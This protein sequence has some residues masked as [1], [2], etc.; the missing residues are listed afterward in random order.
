M[1]NRRLSSSLSFAVPILLLLGVGLGAQESPRGSQETASARPA[2]VPESFAITPFGYFHPSCVRSLAENELV[3]ADGRV[4]HANGTT[5][6]QAPACGFPHFTATGV[7]VTE[8]AK[9]PLEANLAAGNLPTIHGWLEYVSATTDT[10]YREISATWPVPAAPATIQGQTLFFFP[11]FEDYN[12]ILSIVQP[13]LQWGRSSDG[14]GNYWGIASWTCCI[15]GTTFH[16]RLLK[17]STGDTILGAILPSC[18]AKKK[19]QSCTTWKITTEDLTTGQKSQLA[20]SPAEGQVW[21]WGFAAVAEVYGVS[22]CSDFPADAGVTFSAQLYDNNGVLIS[23]PGWSGTP[24]GS[25]VTP[26]CNYGLDFTNS[27]QTLEY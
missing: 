27:E 25:G 21:N 17:V 9:A 22:Q 23:D 26:Q 8:N 3:L 4:Q 7:L 2:S 14:G 6:V 12:N 11:G 10:S 13:V 1:K 18:K 20:Q 24:A 15:L 5:D 16:S 19:I